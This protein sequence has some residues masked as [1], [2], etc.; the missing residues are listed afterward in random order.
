[1][2]GRCLQVETTV[3]SYEDAERIAE[4]LVGARLAACCQIVGPATSVYRW[5]GVVQRE[6]EF[7]ILM[8]THS[9]RVEELKARLAR[10]HPYE[11]PQVLVFEV[12]DGAGPYLAW[13]TS[14]TGAA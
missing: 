9:D 14:E 8:K 10:G 12:I 13:I 1:M 7:L 3:G 5:E 2:E 4:E 6:Q 11:V